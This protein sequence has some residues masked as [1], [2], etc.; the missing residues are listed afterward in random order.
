MSFR[1]K[2]TSGVTKRGEFIILTGRPGKGKT[3]LASEFKRYGD[4]AFIDLDNSSHNI[5]GV[6]RMDASQLPDFKSFMAILNG[7]AKDSEGFKTI[8]IDSTTCLESYIHKHICGDKYA[9]IVEYE[10]GFGAGYQRAREILKAEVCAVIKKICA[11]GTNVVACAHTQV[12]NVTDPFLATSYM[13]YSL[14]GHEKFTEILLNEADHV[15]FINDD[16]EVIKSKSDRVGKADNEA[17]ERYIL[18]QALPAA[19]AKTRR[20]MPLKVPFDEKE[21]N[22]F[23]AAFEAAKPTETAEEIIE[24]IKMVS[25]FASNEDLA[26]AKARVQE[27]AGDVAKLTKIRDR[28][29]KTLFNN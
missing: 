3:T 29:L 2:A 11:A 17:S 21:G 20:P 15:F 19:D 22:K 18:T 10:N 24:Q 9:S 7:F 4:V 25:K 14:Q 12:K 6:S 23:F 13:R 16:V 1:S 5:T 26:N 8:V 28:V 27:A